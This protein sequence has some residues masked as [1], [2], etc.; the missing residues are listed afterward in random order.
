M[1]QRGGP[2]YLRPAWDT[3]LRAFSVFCQYHHTAL[4]LLFEVPPLLLYPRTWVTSAVLRMTP[5]PAPA[6]VDDEA[7]FFGWSGPP[8]PSAERPWPTASPPP[9]PACTRKRHPGGYPDLRPRPGR[10]RGTAWHPG[11]RSPLRRLSCGPSPNEPSCPFLKHS[12]RVETGPS[13]TGRPGLY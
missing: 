12:V 7:H 5:R 9:C 1:I 2:A 8:S 4:E 11:V 13:Q 3:G 10:P 6:E